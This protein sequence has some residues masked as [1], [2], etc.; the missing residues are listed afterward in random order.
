[1]KFQ[2]A[3]TAVLLALAVIL[4]S[5]RHSPASAQPET[6]NILIIGHS[7][8][9]SAADQLNLIAAEAGGF[10]ADEVIHGGY[11]LEDQWNDPEQMAQI[12]AALQTG[13]YAYAAIMDFAGI[14]GHESGPIPFLTNNT[15]FD[16]LFR[17]HGVQLV[18]IEPWAPVPYP[19][20]ITQIARNTASVSATLGAP[21]A[22]VGDAFAL[23]NA[24]MPHLMLTKSPEDSHPSPEGAYLRDLV[25]YA[26]IMGKH[27]G[28]L[29]GVFALSE[30]D[31]TQLKDLAWQAV[32]DWNNAP[33]PP[34]IAPGTATR[35]PRST[36]T[37]APTETA[38]LPGETPSPTAAPASPTAAA[39]PSP[40][41]SASPAISPTAVAIAP[42]AFTPTLTAHAASPAPPD[43]ADAAVPPAAPSL[44]YIF[45]GLFCVGLISLGM[46]AWAVRKLTR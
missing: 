15:R 3:S 2:H 10:H 7:W 12:T 39:L 34:T 28:E 23:V 14:A 43:T 27:P 37:P 41:A 40:T 45:A 6:T 29:D 26:A 4:S 30:E 44:P 38:A 16:E 18:I 8:V 20:I 11:S 24:E 25:I 21:V 1:M 17:E 22:P 9:A 13:I 19:G 5:A 35:L 31:E 46:V 33:P 36:E 42:P 32:L